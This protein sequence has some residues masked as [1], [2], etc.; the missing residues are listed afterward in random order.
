MRQRVYI[1]VSGKGKRGHSANL[2]IAKNIAQLLHLSSFNSVIIESWF[3][4]IVS[5]DLN[6]VLEEK[7]HKILM[8]GTL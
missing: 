8:H 6:Y 4:I 7:R 3:R 5:S 1:T 2:F